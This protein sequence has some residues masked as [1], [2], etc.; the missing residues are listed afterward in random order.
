MKRRLVALVVVAL[1]V[2]M[3]VSGCGSSGGGTSSDLSCAPSDPIDP[4]Y[5]LSGSWTMFITLDGD[6]PSQVTSLTC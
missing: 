4:S 5:D 2:V 6:C 3:F 1:T